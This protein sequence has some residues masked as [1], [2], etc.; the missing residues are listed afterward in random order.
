MAENC[1]KWHLDFRL[2][3]LIVCGLSLLTSCSNDDTDDEQPP[4]KVT[5]WECILFGSY[6]ANEVVS[7]S[8][9]AVDDYAL[10]EG[11]VI[12]DATLYHQLE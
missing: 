11:D 7:G 12:T 3:L 5:R 10:L 8:F 4:Q 6:P 1:E 9:S 2:A